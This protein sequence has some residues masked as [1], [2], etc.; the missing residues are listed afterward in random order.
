MHKKLSS[1]LQTSSGR[2][3]IPSVDRVL[4]LAS[5]RSLIDQYGRDLVTDAVRDELNGLR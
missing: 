5:I 3:A 1:E 4:N 2:A